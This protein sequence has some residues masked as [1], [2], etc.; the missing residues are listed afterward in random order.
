MATALAARAV[1]LGAARSI[2]MDETLFTR[3]LTR[4]Q[5]IRMILLEAGVPELEEDLDPAD[6][7]RAEGRAEGELMGLRVAIATALA[8]RGLPLS[9]GGC[10]RL[11]SCAEPTILARWLTRAVTAV[12]EAD[13]FADDGAQ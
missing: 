13:I 2:S 10:A 7:W 6:Q 3:R 1:P 8:A 12:S 9:D 5:E 4:V 11:A